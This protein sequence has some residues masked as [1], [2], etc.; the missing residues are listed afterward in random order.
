MEIFYLLSVFLLFGAFLTPS[1]QRFYLFISFIILFILAA[2]REVSVGTDTQ[3]Y[4]ELFYRLKRGIPIRQEIGWQY[5]NKIVIYFGGGFEYVLIVS[6]LLVLLPVFFVSKNYSDNPMLSIF[7][8]FA[9][10]I[11][12]QSFNITRQT[13]AVS[14]VLIAYTFLLKNQYWRYC[15]I[16]G[17]ASLFHITALLCLP[18]VFIDRVPDKKFI[19]LALIGGSLLFGVVFSNFILINSASLFG[20]ENYLERFDSGVGVG[21][22]LLAL[23]AFGV[24]VVFSA[25]DRGTLFKLFIVYIVFANLTSAVPFGYRIIFYF[26]IVQILFL[27]S[28]VRANVFKPPQLAFF[29]VIIYAYIV[30]SRSAGS[31][32]IVPYINI[33]F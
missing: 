18:L 17:V 26:T 13:I 28:F 11:Y 3:G 15:L 30:F 22:F 9:F 23:N 29:L 20:Y 21:V 33:L 25:R 12:L 2:F 1:H 4:E 24:F 8:Y 10:Y 7:L 5:L 16:I 27:P 31:G 19:F 14:I 32:E 6:S